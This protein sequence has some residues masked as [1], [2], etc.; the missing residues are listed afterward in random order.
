[1][2][3][4][5]YKALST[6]TPTSFH[7]LLTPYTPPH[8]LRSSGA[9]LLAEPQYRTVMGSRAFHFSAPKEWNRLPLPI[10]SSNSLRSFKKWL[11]T[12]YFSLAFKELES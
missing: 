8:C 1:L 11:K 9:R 12:H 4:L 5:T 7:A 2:A 3:C 6:S 10:R